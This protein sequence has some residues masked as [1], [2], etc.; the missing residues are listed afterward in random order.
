MLKLARAP[1]QACIFRQNEA[2]GA[3]GIG[4]AAYVDAHATFVAS[5]TTFADNVAIAR[6]AH[7]GDNVALVGHGASFTAVCAGPGTNMTSA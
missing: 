6:G 2:A 1:P 4:G 7:Y 3:Q 5:D